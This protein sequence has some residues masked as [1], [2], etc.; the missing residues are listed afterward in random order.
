MGWTMKGAT[1]NIPHPPQKLKHKRRNML[2]VLASSIMSSHVC[3]ICRRKEIWSVSGWLQ[4]DHPRYKEKNG[5]STV[6][7]ECVKLNPEVF[8]NHGWA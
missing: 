7:N 8:E 2:E 4:I 3:Q 5:G 6:C 1:Y